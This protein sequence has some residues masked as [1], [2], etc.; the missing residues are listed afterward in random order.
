M[1]IADDIIIIQAQT[2]LQNTN[3]SS[4]HADLPQNIHTSTES[5]KLRTIEQSI[6]NFLQH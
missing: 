3:P 4:N 6:M 1:A 2:T 5:S